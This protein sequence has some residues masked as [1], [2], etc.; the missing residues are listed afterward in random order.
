MSLPISVSRFPRELQGKA[1]VWW[2]GQRKVRRKVLRGM[3]HVALEVQSCIDVYK[4]PRAE[5]G[6]QAESGRKKGHLS[7]L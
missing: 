6:E 1:S 7:G 2:V 5:K 3:L 4:S